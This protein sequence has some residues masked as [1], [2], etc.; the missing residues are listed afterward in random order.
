[1]RARGRSFEEFG[2]TIVVNKI[3][4]GEDNNRKTTGK[5]ESG[6]VPRAGPVSEMIGFLQSRCALV[7]S[8]CSSSNELGDIPYG[9]GSMQAHCQIDTSSASQDRARA[10]EN[11]SRGLYGVAWTLPHPGT[12]SEETR[13]GTPTPRWAFSRALFSFS[14]GPSFVELAVIFGHAFHIA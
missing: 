1:M 2:E 13:N 11:D 14:Q 5:D 9:L 6:L 12:A 4:D 10:F 7:P 3:K 8:L